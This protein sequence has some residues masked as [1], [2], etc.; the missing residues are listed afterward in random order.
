MNDMTYYKT[1]THFTPLEAAALLYDILPTGPDMELPEPAAALRDELAGIFG[2][3]DGRRFPRTYLREKADKLGL[4]PEFLRPE[5][6][7][8]TGLSREDFLKSAMQEMLG[9]DWREVYDEE[10]APHLDEPD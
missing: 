5:T 2:D 1:L 4:D 9:G 6:L 7:Y 8:D 3:P 10:I